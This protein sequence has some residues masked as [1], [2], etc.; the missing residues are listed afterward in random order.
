MNL[1]QIRQR[2]R[3]LSGRYDLVNED[4]SDNG[5]DFFINEGRKFLDRMDETQKSWATCYRFI[6]LGLYSAS[7][8]HCRAIKEAWAATSIARWQLEKVSLQDLIAGYMTGMPS[9][10]N[11]GTPLYYSPTITRHAPEEI[12]SADFESF[13]GWVDIPSGNA[14]EYN[15]ILLNVPTSERIIVE[16]KGLFYSLE[17]EEDTDMNYWSSMH[18]MLLIM[19]A[20]RQVEIVNRNTQGVNDWTSAI[21]VEMTQLGMDLVEEHIAE[22]NQMEG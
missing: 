14:H 19:S 12:S 22:V 16:V 3:E 5:A 7:I 18:P 6:E 21:T 4:G 9:S 17:L 20:L 2:F 13:I 11:L 1:L 15:T 10:R 8:P